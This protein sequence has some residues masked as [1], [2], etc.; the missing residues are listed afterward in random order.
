MHLNERDRQIP[1]KTGPSQE[2]KCGFESRNSQQE[3]YVAVKLATL[4]T[5]LC[6]VRTLL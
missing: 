5:A 3:P 2:E 6:E 1:S 4:N